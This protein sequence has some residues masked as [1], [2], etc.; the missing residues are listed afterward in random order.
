MR[1][2][3]SLHRHANFHPDKPYGEEMQVPAL[4]EPTTL[5]LAVAWRP[6]LIGE[7]DHVHHVDAF[8]L[9]FRQPGALHGT[10]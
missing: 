2:A 6:V 7:I 10:A 3:P 1:C 5:P 8:A 4:P 9:A